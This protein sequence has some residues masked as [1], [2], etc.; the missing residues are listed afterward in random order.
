MSNYTIKQCIPDS[1]L[2]VSVLSFLNGMKR[3]LE[4]CSLRGDDFE[5]T[6]NCVNNIIKECEPLNRREQAGYM[7]TLA[8][9]PGILVIE[10]H[11][12]SKT[13]VVARITFAQ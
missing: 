2:P 9:G 6:A 3:Q 7:L 1:K 5:R 4:I 11:L 8:S 13:V 10:K 12:A